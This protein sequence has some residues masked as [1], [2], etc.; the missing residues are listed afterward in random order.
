MG[1]PDPPHSSMSPI[2]PHP[3]TQRG[4]QRPLGGTEGGKHRTPSPTP[5]L[6]RKR[7]GQNFVVRFFRTVPPIALI[8]LGGGQKP[9]SQVYKTLILNDVASRVK[10]KSWVSFRQNHEPLGWNRLRTGARRKAEEIQRPSRVLPAECVPEETP[11]LLPAVAEKAVDPR[12]VSGIAA[13]LPHRG[14]PG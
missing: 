1:R 2:P 9:S 14:G 7:V 3:P 10:S 8:A 12:P 6:L 4:N 5:L 13:P 11:E